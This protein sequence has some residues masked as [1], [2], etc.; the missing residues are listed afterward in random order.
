MQQKYKSLKK[1][2]RHVSAGVK[3]DIAK[4]GNMALTTS[5]VNALQEQTPLLSLRARMGPSASG[6]SSEHCMYIWEDLHMKKLFKP[7]I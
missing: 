1:Q 2:A 7:V 5:T 6:F 3:K 4:T